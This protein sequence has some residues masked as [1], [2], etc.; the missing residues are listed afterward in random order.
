[1]KRTC[2]FLL[3]I[4]IL[5]SCCSPNKRDLKQ[6]TLEG[7]INDIET[8][9]VV[10]KYWP[11]KTL[12]CDTVKIINGN[13]SYKGKIVETG[14]ATIYWGNNHQ[15]MI[16]LDPGK[17]KISLSKNNYPEFIMTG[18]KTQNDFDRFEKSIKP[19]HDKI[20]NT[21]KQYNGIK[22]S[23][24][25]STDV[26]SRS[27]LEKRLYETKSYLT[28]YNKKIDSIKIQFV[29]ENT[30]SFCS[31]FLLNELQGNEVI[32]KDSTILLLNR[33]DNSLKN[34]QYA[35]TISDDIRKKTNIEIGVQAPDFKALDINQSPVTLSQFKG[36]NVILMDFWAS[37]CDPCRQSIPHLKEIY[38]KYHSKGLEI[39][40]VS[41]DDDKQAWVEA[42]HKDN[43]ELWYNV[44]IAEKSDPAEEYYTDDDIGKNYFIGTIPTQILI[45][46]EG[47]IINR[48]EGRSEDIE[49][50]IDK[51]LSGLF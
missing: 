42:I 20:L 39:V 11:D 18:S 50:S 35:K 9:N 26:S 5:Y 24:N 19:I 43:T 2:T 4:L 33:L 48:W 7:T 6:F 36:K 41:I 15:S 13:F 8:G 27:K 47:K 28:L 40:A 32:S 30:A 44:P 29:T 23:I 51:A 22:D 16:Y 25:V 12:I 31:I 3:T 37:W 10:I 17:M 45:N 34:D 38:N 14:P 1:M 49:A 46:K 21:I